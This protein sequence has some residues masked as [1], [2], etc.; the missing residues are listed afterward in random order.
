M[1]SSRYKIDDFCNGLQ[2]FVSTSQRG[3]GEVLEEKLVYT[4][5]FA[6]A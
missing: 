6:Q 1:S 4:T 5:G 3:S 2:C